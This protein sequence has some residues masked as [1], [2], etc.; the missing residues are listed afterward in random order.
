LAAP[1]GVNSVERLI[2]GQGERAAIGGQRSRPRFHRR[3]RRGGEH[4][5][6]AV[7]QGDVG[8]RRFRPWSGGGAGGGR[9][10]VQ[11][12]SERDRLGRLHHQHVV[13]DVIVAPDGEGAALDSNA[14][15][16]S[17]GRAR[18]EEAGG[19]PDRAGGDRDVHPGCRPGQ[20]AGRRERQEK[21][22]LAVDAS[23]DV[24]LLRRG[25]EVV[26]D[27][28]ARA[29]GKRAERSRGGERGRPFREGR[30]DRQPQRGLATHEA[31]GGVGGG[32]GEVLSD[33]V[34]KL[35]GQAGIR[36]W[37]GRF[38]IDVPGGLR[39]AVE[40]RTPEI[41]QLSGGCLGGGL[42]IAGGGKE[43]C[44]QVGPVHTLASS[45][46]HRSQRSA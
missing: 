1:E 28:P 6:H 32:R 3:E 45:I 21:E 26:P 18:G 44:E 22:I 9:P 31:D 13:G 29:I 19:D 41:V 12:H 43:R 36:R 23:A 39:E 27:E 38:S 34:L 24:K 40:E 10:G 42:Q 30:I 35:G 7:G 16:S 5:G 37:G 14:S 17:G 33:Q 4:E 46:R 2:A 20:T 15:V 11:G 8:V 25:E